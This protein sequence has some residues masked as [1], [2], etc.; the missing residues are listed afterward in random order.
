MFIMVVS[1]VSPGSGRDE[2]TSAP[3]PSATRRAAAAPSPRRAT[4][5]RWN[6]PT[7]MRATMD[8]HPLTGAC[9]HDP[10]EAERVYGPLALPAASAAAST[11]SAKG[12]TVKLL[13][14]QL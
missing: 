13:C 3:R 4:P 8:H 10:R 2:M 11:P 9:A 1:W 14:P 12:L 5:R 6:G 7:S